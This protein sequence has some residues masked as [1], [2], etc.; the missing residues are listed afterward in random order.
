[1]RAD[2][3]MNVN[4]G[5]CETTA[6]LAIL[7]YVR[8]HVVYGQVHTLSNSLLSALLQLSDTDCFTYGFDKGGYPSLLHTTDTLLRQV[9]IQQHATCSRCR[10]IDF[11]IP[12]YFHCE[13]CL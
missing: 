13:H 5:Q 3:S 11:P 2:T 10:N 12:S 1:M 7:H 9:Y 8:A 4:G 6:Y